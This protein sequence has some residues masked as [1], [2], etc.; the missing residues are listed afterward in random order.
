M[1]NLNQLPVSW[2][3]LLQDEFSKPYFKKIRLFLTQETKSLHTIF[4]ASDQIFQAFKDTPLNDLKVVILGQDP[5]HS[6]DLKSE[7][8]HAHGLAFSIPKSAQKIPPSLKNIFKELQSD[9]D[10]YKIPKHGNLTK[11][12]QQGVLLLN[13]A[14]TVRA[15]QANSHSKIGWQ[16]FT[17]TVIQKVSQ[18]TDQKVFI[19]WGNYARSKKTLIDTKKHLVLESP[20]PSPFSARKGFFGSNPFSK[21]NQYLEKHKQRPIDWQS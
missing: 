21:A 16:K 10:S 15:H 5:Y 20:H 7:L 2:Q 1:L 12:A 9:L 11:W 14:L 8:A 17:D 19:L 13:S 4:P 3:N 18:T 6:I